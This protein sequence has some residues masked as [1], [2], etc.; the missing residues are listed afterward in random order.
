MFTESADGV[1]PELLKALHE[2]MQAFKKVA[3]AKAKRMKKM[4][5]LK[6]KAAKGGVL[7][8]SAQ[9]ELECM[10][11]EDE[12]ERNRQEITAAAAQRRAKKAV[13]N[14]D[15]VTGGRRADGGGGGCWWWWYS[16]CCLVVVLVVPV[17]HEETCHGRGEKETGGGKEI[18]ERSR[19]KEKTG[20]SSEI[21]GQ[22]CNV[23]K[24]NTVS[25]PVAFRF[26]RLL[27]VV[28]CTCNT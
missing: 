15:K 21:G 3:A 10:V 6:A 20:E 19:E 16:R 17:G 11:R 26:S 22:S 25:M 4:D 13:K 8:K 9:H 12:T 2:A 7:G 14:A 5:K 28:T 27:P 24:M 18:E 23:C 1:D